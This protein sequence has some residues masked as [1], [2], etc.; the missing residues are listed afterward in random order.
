MHPRRLEGKANAEEF[1]ARMEDLAQA[2]ALRKNT[3]PK[4]N[5]DAL[6]AKLTFPKDPFVLKRKGL[7]L[8]SY[9]GDGMFRPSILLDRD[10]SG[11]LAVWDLLELKGNLSKMA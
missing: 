10:G 4:N 8:Q 11:F 5:N 3:F 1:T 6:S 2:E 7:H 9:S